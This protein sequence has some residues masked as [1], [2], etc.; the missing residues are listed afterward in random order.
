MQPMRI[1]GLA[2]RRLANE[3]LMSSGDEMAGGVER[4]QCNR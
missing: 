1:P 3:A 4:A 2:G